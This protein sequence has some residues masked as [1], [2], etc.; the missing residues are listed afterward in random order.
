MNPNRTRVIENLQNVKERLV[1]IA[2]FAVQE[3]PNQLADKLTHDDLAQMVEGTYA[4]MSEFFGDGPGD[5]W[6]SYMEMVIPG[7]LNAGSSPLG[8]LRTVTAY[9]SL[10]AV[11]L[12]RTLA[13]LPERQDCL[14]EFVRFAVQWHA[15][16]AEAAFKRGE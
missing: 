5:F 3:D 2:V 6:N 12:D 11:E 13:S 7:L 16:I 1:D 8:M 10:V 9:H 4:A 15:D 14:E